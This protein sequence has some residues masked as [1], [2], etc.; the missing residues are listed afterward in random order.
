MELQHAINLVREKF[1]AESQDQTDGD[2]VDR[3][4]DAFEQY[5]VLMEVATHIWAQQLIQQNIARQL[6][7][8]QQQE[9]G[10][11]PGQGTPNQ[12]GQP[13]LS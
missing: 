4:A 10:Q 7:Q 9:G 6:A 2:V 5:P 1:T 12:G 8:R 11:T 3:Y 13:P